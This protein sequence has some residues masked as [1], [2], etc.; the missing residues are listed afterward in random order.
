MNFKLGFIGFT[1][2]S[3]LLVGCSKEPPV[4]TVQEIPVTEEEYSSVLSYINEKNLKI[5]EEVVR[6]ESGKVIDD[7]KVENGDNM[8]WSGKEHL[9]LV[10]VIPGVKF[11][12][13]SIGIEK[14]YDENND[15]VTFLVVDGLSLIH[16]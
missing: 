14:F 15:K 10:H 4:P 5:D 16:I 6:D 12:V 3:L 2:L 8:L 7:N 9:S 1:S 11:G 13:N